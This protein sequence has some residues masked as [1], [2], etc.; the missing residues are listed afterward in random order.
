[1][2]KL[3]TKQTINNKEVFI[4]YKI[5]VD[6]V[7]IEANQTLIL[8]LKRM[9]S[10][11]RVNNSFHTLSRIDYGKSL[12][13]IN[14][15]REQIGD[16]IHNDEKIDNLTIKRK[17]SNTNETLKVKGEYKIIKIDGLENT[18]YFSFYNFDK[19]QQLIEVPLKEGETISY[20][21][22]KI[23]LPQGTQMQKSEIISYESN[24]DDLA[25]YSNYSIIN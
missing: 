14:H 25:E 9:D 2:I 21:E 16:V 19:Q 13:Q 20:L 11:Y 10:C 7:L 24:S 12:E 5:E 18:A 1:M 4:N 6:K 23:I 15:L 22:S 3:K 17:F 8:Y